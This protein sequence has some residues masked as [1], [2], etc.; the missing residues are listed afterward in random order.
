MNL[1]EPPPG[2]Q[3]MPPAARTAWLIGGIIHVSMV[4]FLPIMVG[5]MVLVSVEDPRWLLVIGIGPALAL[6]LALGWGLIASH[7]RYRSSF[8]M[9][10]DDEIM[11]QRGVFRVHRAVVP[12]ARVQNVETVHG[13]IDRKLGLVNVKI[14]TAASPVTIAG[15][16]V[17][18]GERLRSEMIRRVKLVRDRLSA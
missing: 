17:E 4:A 1:R 14:Y 15:L 2:A 18:T 3:R 5:V 10:S 12:F 16:G 6:V 9:V 11:I 7:L 8:Y 13:P